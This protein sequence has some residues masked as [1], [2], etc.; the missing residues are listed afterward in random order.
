L[1]ASHAQRDIFAQILIEAAIGAGHTDLA[2]DLLADRS[3]L[4]PNSHYTWQRYAD[5]LQA[6]G[7][8]E[9]A[10]GARARAAA[11]H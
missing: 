2:R 3:K 1:G 5:A 7:D 9:A 6:C 10:R 8:L 11:V 4:K